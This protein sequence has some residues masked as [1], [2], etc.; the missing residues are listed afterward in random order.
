[1]NESLNFN[2]NFIIKMS[3]ITFRNLLCNSHSLRKILDYIRCA[4]N[5]HLSRAKRKS[6]CT[7]YKV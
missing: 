7:S 5:I 4:N 2:E 6:K 1:M 3:H